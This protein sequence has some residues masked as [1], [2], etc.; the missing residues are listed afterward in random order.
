MQALLQQAVYDAMTYSGFAGWTTPLPKPPTTVGNIRMTVYNDLDRDGVRDTGEA[1]WSGVKVFI[2]ADNDGVLDTGEKSGT[3][4]T[5]GQ[6]TFASLPA[7]SSHRVRI[8]PPSNTKTT[9]SNPVLAS[10]AA[11]ATK[12]VRTGLTKLGSIAGRVFSDNNKNGRLDT[13]EE[14]LAGRTVFIDLDNDNFLDTN[15]KRTTTDALGNF[16]FTGL[17]SG[18]Y[19]IKRVFPSGY[20][21]STPASVVNLAAGQNFSGVLIGAAKI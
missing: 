9:S 12:D 1:I 19:R 17:L 20:R 7:G 2:D 13:G 16:K 11:G 5:W 10:V 3:T 15:E 18:T 8:V 6:V 4:N 21:L 14:L